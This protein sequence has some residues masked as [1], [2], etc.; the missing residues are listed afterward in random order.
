MSIRGLVS[1]TSALEARAPSSPRAQLSELPIRNGMREMFRADLAPVRQLLFATGHCRELLDDAARAYGLDCGLMSGFDN[2]RLDVD[3]FS[4]A[5]R[6]SR[7]FFAPCATRPTRRF[8]ICPAYRSIGN[9]RLKVS[10]WRHHFEVV[11]P[12]ASGCRHPPRFSPARCMAVRI[13]EGLDSS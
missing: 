12:R 6:S 4:R 11:K 7:T 3:C 1:V 9:H 8:H 2:A 5:R 13:I 10:A